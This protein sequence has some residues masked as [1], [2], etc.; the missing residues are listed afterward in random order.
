MKVDKGHPKFGT[1]TGREY[2]AHS[3]TRSN[4]SIAVDVPLVR[5]FFS[6]FRVWVH[7]S[8]F[9][10]F[11]A[12]TFHEGIFTWINTRVTGI[13]T[14]YSRWCHLRAQ[15]VLE[16]HCGLSRACRRRDVIC[17]REYAGFWIPQL[18]H[19]LVSTARENDTRKGNA[20]FANQRY[21]WQGEGLDISLAPVHWS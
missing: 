3:K 20:V 12:S 15:Q 4:R 11:R 6:V 21:L 7:L 13:P 16:T 19:W 17:H 8:S 10:Y 5:G 18:L 9:S 1:R 2:L 14:P